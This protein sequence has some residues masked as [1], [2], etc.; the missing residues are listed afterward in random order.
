MAL[1]LHDQLYIYFNGKLLVNVTSIDSTLAGDD[2]TVMTIAK[3]F[4][5]RCWP[6]G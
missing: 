5:R 1:D 4:A 3:G 6:P 2:Q